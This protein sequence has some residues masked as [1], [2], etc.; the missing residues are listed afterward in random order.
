MNYL[1][2]GNWAFSATHQYLDDNPTNSAS[3]VYT[4]KATITDDDTG[5]NCATTTT[6]ISNVTTTS[7][8]LC[9][10]AVIENG[11]VTLAGTFHDDGTQDTHT[12]VI[13]WNALGN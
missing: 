8:A 3:D 10:S 7:I 2:G 4:I 9:A 6:T 5:T 13:N 11:S 12:I 1:G